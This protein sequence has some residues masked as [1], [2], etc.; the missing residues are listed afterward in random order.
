MP[1]VFITFLHSVFIKTLDDWNPY[2]KN[3]RQ[4]FPRI[5]NKVCEEWGASVEFPENELWKYRLGENNI[6]IREGNLHTITFVEDKE[7]PEDSFTFLKMLQDK[8]VKA[9]L[10]IAIMD[11]V[12]RQREILE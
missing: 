10:R 2:E 12:T 9:G 1:T 3:L 6:S 8:C 4:E 11:K 5:W 7:L